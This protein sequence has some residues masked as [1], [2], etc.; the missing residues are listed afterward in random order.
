MGIRNICE[1]FSDDEFALLERAK[2]GR[3]WRKFLLDV[4]H[5]I[6]LKEFEKKSEEELNREKKREISSNWQ[7]K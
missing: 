7:S 2:D 6:Q 3:T 5:E 4:A 1:Q